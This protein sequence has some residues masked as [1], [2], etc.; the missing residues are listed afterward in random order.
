MVFEDEVSFQA[1]KD[2]DIAIM[3]EGDVIA[4]CIDFL[5]AFECFFASF[6]VFH[7]D[8]PSPIKKNSCIFTKN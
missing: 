7:L 2:D 1:A 5:Q 6:Y 3:V 4:K 8:Y